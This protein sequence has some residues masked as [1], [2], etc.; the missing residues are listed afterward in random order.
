MKFYQCLQQGEMASLGLLVNKIAVGLLVI[1]TLANAEVGI[2]SYY[3]DR[4]HG[5]IM[6][7]G[8][9]FDMN[10]VSC[11]TPIING[12]RKWGLG[13]K[14]RV[15]NIKNNKSIQCEITDTG[16]FAKYG[17]SIDLSKRA[18]A[19]LDKLGLGLLKVKVEVVK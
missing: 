10:K 18:F 2:A 1:S 12:K 4:F 9:P 15:T 8:K 17:R 5:K 6:A 7:N 3:A 16:A 14:L 19:R 11:A 13:T